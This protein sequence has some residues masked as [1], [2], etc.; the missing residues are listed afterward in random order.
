MPSIKEHISRWIDS[1]AASRLGQGRS[2]SILLYL[3][4]VV[5]SALLWCFLTFNN[6][7]T[8]DVPMPVRMLNK[9]DDVRFITPVPDSITVSV[10]AKG[11]TF[12]KYIFKAT[13]TIDLKFN[14]YASP[15]GVFKVDQAQLK[16]LIN[17]QLGRSVVLTTVLPESINA[18]YTDQPGK[19]VPVVV[20]IDVK[21]E[22]LHTQNGP[23][24]KSQ[25]SVM[26]YGD[27]A[28]LAAISEV[29][30]YRINA[31]DLTDTLRRR[32][33]IAPL[34]GAVVEPRS[35]DVTVPVEKLVSQRQ[36]V[37]IAVRNVPQGVNVIVF[38][39]SVEVSYR[40][41]VSSQR[42]IHAE[43]TAVVDYNNIVDGQS[44]KVALQV[45]EAPAVYQDIRLS[46]DSV[47]YI[48]EKHSTKP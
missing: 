22:L 21:P 44:R 5:I 24:I 46:T 33:S 14:A 23:I 32:V 3:A 43:V 7:I 13:P 37:Q 38:P 40:A 11:T 30:T 39:S 29:Y 26:V 18:K 41:P 8:V 10:T 45:G 4:F 47:E 1:I 31:K 35:I 17:A 27:A 48:V 2:K 42:K 12:I 25:D 20:D 34:K 9:P 16:K 36:K 6:P 28:T 15:D 19:L